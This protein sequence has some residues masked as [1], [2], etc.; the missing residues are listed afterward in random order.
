MYKLKL[1]SLCLILCAVLLQVGYAR[2]N[3]VNPSIACAPGNCT[4]G[5]TPTPRPT[6][7]P[8]P[9][10]TPIPV[11]TPT[12]SAVPVIQAQILAGLNKAFPGSANSTTD[13]Y[14]SGSYAMANWISGEQGGVDIFV[15]SNGTW[16]A[17]FGGAGMVDEPTLVAHGVPAATAAALLSQVSPL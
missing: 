10:P 13:I 7:V 1:C 16:T 15:L 6:V 3:A 8:T 4:G 12:P 2:A 14:F 17:L 11:P 9:T 5:G